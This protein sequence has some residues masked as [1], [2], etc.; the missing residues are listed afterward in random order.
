MKIRQSIIIRDIEAFGCEVVRE[1]FTWCEGKGGWPVVSTA[2]ICP[3]CLR[4][5][6]H[7][8]TVEPQDAFKGYHIQKNYCLSCT[9][10]EILKPFSDIPQ[11]I[12][13]RG[14]LITYDISNHIDWGLLEALPERLLRRE[15]Q[16][17]LEAFSG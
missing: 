14:S 16:L 12:R 13:P 2:H 17:T 11:F 1:D 9:P 7:I 5:W 15:F 4:V 10:E 6:A 3:S 8:R